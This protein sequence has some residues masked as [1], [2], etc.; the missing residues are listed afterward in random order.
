[1]NACLSTSKSFLKKTEIN[2]LTYPPTRNK[3]DVKYLC[4]L[5]QQ[6]LINVHQA[7][8]CGCRYCLE[9]LKKL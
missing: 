7:D 4:P 8:D 3:V 5:C 1:M 9:C 2:E 6:I